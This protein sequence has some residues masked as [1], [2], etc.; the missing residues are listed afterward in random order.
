MVDFPFCHFEGWKI[1]LN[2]L[3]NNDFTSQ[4]SVKFIFLILIRFGENVKSSH[5][6]NQ[7]FGENGD[8]YQIL[9]NDNW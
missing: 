1:K 5:E 8:F 9:R 7:G 6:K 2:N 3:D 4:H